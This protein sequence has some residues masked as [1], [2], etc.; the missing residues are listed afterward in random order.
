MK[1]VPGVIT[2][3]D[4]HVWTLTSG[5]ISMSG[6]VVVPDLASHPRV[7]TDVQRVVRELGIGHVTIQMECLDECVPDSLGPLTPRRADAH[8]GHSHEGHPPH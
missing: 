2:V 4:L 3:H 6:H 5:V 8:A 1:A 7:L